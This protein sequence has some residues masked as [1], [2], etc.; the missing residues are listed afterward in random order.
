[1]R[2]SVWFASPTGRLT[3]QLAED[4]YLRL[5]VEGVVTEYKVGLCINL[6]F[7]RKVMLVVRVIYIYIYIYIYYSHL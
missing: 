7:D 3:P 1:L 2:N 4:P 6:S 5:I